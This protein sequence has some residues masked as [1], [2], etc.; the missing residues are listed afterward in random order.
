MKKYALFFLLF[1]AF[2]CQ[3]TLKIAEVKPQST[4]VETINM[5]TADVDITAMIAPYKK[6]LDAEMNQVIGQSSLTMT[7]AAP[8]STL[9]NWMADVLHKKSEEYYQQPIDF[10]IVN[11]GGIRSSELR[12]GPVTKGKLFEL[13]PFD[14]ML[15][16]LTLDGKVVQ[17]L[18][19]H[20]ANR[21]GWPIS[22]PVSYEIN[23]GKAQQIKIHGKALDFDAIYKVALMDFIANGGD[24]CFFLKDQPRKDLGYLF[25]AV[26]IEF[27]E[28]ETAAGRPLASKMDDRVRKIDKSSK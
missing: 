24:R 8:Q 28:E 9:G 5:P 10:A 1:T 17:Q 25:R 2:S 26:I 14:N 7:K 20:M 21:N 22:A 6:Q 23:D 15:V 27:V 4:W 12:K 18:F 11:Y 3:K 13:M 16:V 19:D